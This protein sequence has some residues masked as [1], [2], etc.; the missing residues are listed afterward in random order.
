LQPKHWFVFIALGAIW[1]AS[2]L[3]IK[4]AIEELGPFTIVSYRVLFGLIFAGLIVFIRRLQWPRNLKEWIPFFIL[5][6]TNMSIP[7]FLITWGEQYID[8]AVASILNATV[9]LFT[10]LIAHF[11]IQDDRIT[12]QKLIGLLIAFGGVVVLMSKDLGSSQS[13]LLGQL[14]VIFAAISY[15]ISTVY[16]RRNTLHVEGIVRG[17]SPLVSAAVSA[18]IA[19]FIFESPIKIPILPITWVALLWLGVLGSGLAFMMIFYLI[20][21]IGPTRASMVTYLFPLGG[22]IL[23]VLFLNETLSWQL[24]TGSLCII[25]GIAVVNWKTSATK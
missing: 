20:H 23:G 6:L 24:V 13:S 4:Y 5:G 25:L 21:E 7:F 2:F 15:A 17:T 14:A 22:V 1:S 10:L 11:F 18:W 8:S 19:S 3:W 16:A 9:P 12:P